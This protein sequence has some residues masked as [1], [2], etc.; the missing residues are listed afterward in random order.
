[1]DLFVLWVAFIGAWL[2]FA[3]PIYQATLELLEEQIEMDRIQAVS[4]RVPMPPPV[5]R[6]WWVL[7]PVR[8]ALSRRRTSRIRD[9]VVAEL[10]DADYAAVMQFA[11]KA[12]GWMLVA[13]GGLA[14]AT[15]ETYALDR[16]LQWDV[17]VFVA[18]VVVMA[19][20]SIGYTVTRVVR[21]RRALA[22]RGERT[23]TPTTTQTTTPTVTG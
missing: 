17:A 6:W 16:H 4:A 11:N 20:L 2:L 7:P 19:A 14:I 23:V 22:R 3:G 12:I 9:L 5:S 13:G 8:F 10:D 1:M 21:V 18:L 15:S